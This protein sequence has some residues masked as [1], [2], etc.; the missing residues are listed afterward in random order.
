MRSGHPGIRSRRPARRSGFT[1]L[2]VLVV[3]IIIGVLTATLIPVTLGLLDKWEAFKVA[4]DLNALR[5]AV[6]QFHADVRNHPLRIT[7]TMYQI[8]ETETPLWGWAGDSTPYTESEVDRWHGPYL[9]MPLETTLGADTAFATGFEE[10]VYNHI[11]CINVATGSIVA[12]TC[13]KGD[14]IAFIMS[15]VRIGDFSLVNDIIDP[16]ERNLT[17]EEQGARGKLLFYSYGTI[18]SAFDSGDILYLALPYLVD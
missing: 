10:Y 2:E 17:W 6:Q 4:R 9:D 18:S 11:L 3:I 7:Q 13:E 16:S 5:T 14:W 1:I 8:T 15:D 12:G